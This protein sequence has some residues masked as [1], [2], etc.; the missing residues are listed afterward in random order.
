[1]STAAAGLPLVLVSDE[2]VYEYE[3]AHLPEGAWPPTGWYADW[4]KGVD[5]FDVDPEKCPIEM[6]WLVYEKAQ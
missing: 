2:S 1:L 3:K 6:R 4:V 5:L